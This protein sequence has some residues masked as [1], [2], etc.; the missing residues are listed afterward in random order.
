MKVKNRSLE[1]ISK[2]GLGRCRGKIKGYDK[3]ISEI[4]S[5]I[6]ITDSLGHLTDDLFVK[7]VDIGLQLMVQ[8]SK[9]RERTYAI[10]NVN[11]K[12]IWEEKDFDN[13]Y[14]YVIILLGHG[15]CKTYKYYK[16]Y[17]DIS[18]KRREAGQEAK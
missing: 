11:Y 17:I 1:Q 9:V 18:N 16:R 15:L 8:R 10:T 14:A 4:K 3:R 12:S 5:T 13:R 6:L 2:W 7:L